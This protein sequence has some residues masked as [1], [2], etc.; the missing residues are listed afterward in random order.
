MR[1]NGH[2]GLDSMHALLSRAEKILSLAGSPRISGRV[3]Q[4]CMVLVAS[5]VMIGGSGAV[6]E[7][8]WILMSLEHG[9]LLLH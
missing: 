4:P 6:G 3:A 5:L 7:A 8:T 1:I 2:F 9:G